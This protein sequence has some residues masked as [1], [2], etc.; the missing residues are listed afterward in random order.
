MTSHPLM[1]KATAVWLVDNTALTFIQ[2]AEFCGIHELEVQALAD[3]EVGYGI[4]G[5]NPLDSGELTK[6]EIA[7][8]EKDTALR[9]IAPKSD[10][11]QPRLRSKGPR[12]TPVAKRGD[13]PNAIAYLLKNLP[14]LSD[15]QI[16]KL[17]GTT[18]PTIQ[19]I[20][21]RTHQSIQHLKPEDPVTLGLCRSDELNKALEKAEARVIIE[22]RVPF[23]VQQEKRAEEEAARQAEY[24]AANPPAPAAF[25][26]DAP[27]PDMSSLGAEAWP[28]A[29]PAEETVGAEAWPEVE[30]K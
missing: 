22:G 4:I 16:V 9:L 28:E 5:T 13:K 30:K 23:R 11:P 19:A 21:D 14:D 2:I 12:Y 1:P 10:L 3:G 25:D 7:R 20:R 15:A 18:K 26:T 24:D 29:K 8:C 27:Q 17:V 6:E